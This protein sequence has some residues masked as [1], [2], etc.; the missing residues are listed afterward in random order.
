MS[1]CDRCGDPLT[2]AD[3]DTAGHYRDYCRGCIRELAA[4]SDRERRPPAQWLRETDAPEG[5]DD[6]E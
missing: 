6:G 4:S 2:D 1:E 3:K 5:W